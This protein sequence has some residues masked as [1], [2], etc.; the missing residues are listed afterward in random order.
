MNEQNNEMEKDGWKKVY[1]GGGAHLARVKQEYEELGFE[2]KLVTP[3][4]NECRE[5]TVCYQEGNE[6]LYKLCQKK[7][8]V[9]ML[10]Y[11]RQKN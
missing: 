6:Q 4:L 2:V 8:I 11:Q 9:I 10:P 1:K 7:L 3:S 5:C